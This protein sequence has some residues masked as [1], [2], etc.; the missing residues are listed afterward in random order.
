MLARA[1]NK[2][3]NYHAEKAKLNQVYESKTK[4]LQAEVKKVETFINLSKKKQYV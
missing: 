1:K 2:E 3:M 4:K